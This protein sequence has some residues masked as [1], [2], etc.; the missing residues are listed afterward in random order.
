MG[1]V[2]V[3][4]DLVVVAALAIAVVWFPGTLL[5]AWVTPS[6][7][8]AITVFNVIALLYRGR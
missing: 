6:W 4:V 8:V 1:W 2:L 5:E 3:A 7:L